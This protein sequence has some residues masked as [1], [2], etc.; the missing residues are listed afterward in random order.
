[1]YPVML[2]FEKVIERINSLL[3]NGHSAEALVTSVFT[4][5]KLMK[6][7]VR[8]S[9]V[10]RGFS[11]D[12][13]DRLL[14]GNT[15]DAVLAKWD[16][17][18]KNHKTLPE[19]LGAEWQHIPTAKQMRNALVHG[20]EVYDLKECAAKAQHVIAALIKLHT[21]VLNEYGVDPW[22]KSPRQKTSLQWVS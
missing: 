14:A 15:F 4:F 21:F 10:A 1:M 17:F 6:R 5:E 13:A 16:I 2:S 19:I 8:R 9:I 22:K 20:N 12:Q 3:K 18:F 7:C 11:I